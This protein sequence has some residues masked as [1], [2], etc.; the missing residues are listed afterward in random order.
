M[1]KG[2]KL[3]VCMFGGGRPRA[4]W[5]DTEEVFEHDLAYTTL[6]LLK[7]QDSLCPQGFQGQR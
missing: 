5:E 6:S 2:E 1:S 7:E 3:H 4:V